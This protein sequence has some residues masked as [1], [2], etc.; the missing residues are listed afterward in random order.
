[1]SLSCTIFDILLIVSQNLK[2]LRDRDHAHL[3]DYLS[4]HR[5][6]L[7]MAN[8]CTKFEVSSL[9]RSRDIFGGLKIT[10]ESRDV[11]MH[12]SWTVIRRL[13]L[14]VIKPQTKSE[15]CIFTHYENM[16]INAKCKK[17]GGLGG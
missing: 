3:R 13:R 1:M 10:N 17:M 8:H 12:L 14:A 5:L 9:C 4:T 6:I 2:K 15:V 7:H 16:K 11:T